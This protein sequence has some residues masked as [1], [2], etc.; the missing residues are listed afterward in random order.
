MATCPNCGETSETVSEGRCARCGTSLSGTA[1]AHHSDDPLYPVAFR[2]A[3]FTALLS[4]AALMEELAI[5]RKRAEQLLADLE[6]NGVVGPVVF[7]RSGARESRVTMIND[8]VP[9]GVSTAVELSREPS[10]GQRAL[11]ASGIGVSLG[12]TLALVGIISALGSRILLAWVPALEPGPLV[13]VGSVVLA[14][15]AGALLG[16]VVEFAL[17]P[18]RGLI[19]TW[20]QTGRQALWLVFT[21]VSVGVG[22]LR[23]YQ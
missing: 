18:G 9:G 14:I 10:A 17:M 13:S 4:P 15:A 7:P 12:L 8:P 6:R 3:R 5:D 22:L 21:M 16:F 19:P 20:A 23:L 1:S 11:I 2:L